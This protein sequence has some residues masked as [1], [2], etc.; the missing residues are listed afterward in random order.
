MESMTW[1][2]LLSTRSKNGSILHLVPGPQG[3]GT[4]RKCVKLIWLVQ[5]VILFTL[6][7]NISGDT[8]AVQRADRHYASHYHAEIY[9]IVSRSE[10]IFYI[11]IFVTVSKNGYYR[12]RK[13]KAPALDLQ[14]LDLLRDRH[15]D[16]CRE[17]DNLEELYY[18]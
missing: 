16:I 18:K 1:S 8:E 4:E 17:N 11:A 15:S 10:G 7:P 5:S 6:E 9:T 12:P 2:C 14:A 3:Y 13:R